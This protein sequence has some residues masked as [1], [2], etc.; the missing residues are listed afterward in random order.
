MAVVERATS[1]IHSTEQFFLSPSSP[2]PTL[3]L[4]LSLTHSLLLLLLDST[5]LLK[6][7]IETPHLNVVLLLLKPRRRKKE[8]MCLI[9]FLLVAAVVS[10]KL[11]FYI[12]LFIVTFKFGVYLTVYSMCFCNGE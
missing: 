4:S 3:P 12:H 1:L 8:R 9:P 10:G 6:E 7:E 2:S 5:T 11:F